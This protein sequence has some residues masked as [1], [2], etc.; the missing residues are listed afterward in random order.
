MKHLENEI[1]EIDLIQQNKVF[2]EKFYKKLDS[3]VN[4]TS[5]LMDMN[6]N[7]YKNNNNFSLSSNNKIENTLKECIKYNIIL[8]NKENKDLPSVNDE[9]LKEY[10][11]VTGISISR[12]K[13]LNLKIDF[14][15]LGVKNEYYIILSFQKNIFC[16]VDI[17]P[18][19]INYKKYIEQHNKSED[20]TTFLCKLVNYELIPYYQNNNYK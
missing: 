1:L 8:Q 6:N 13:D 2:K 9:I 16:V 12:T 20:I 3:I 15:F 4:D 14:D 11:K 7:I 19:D 17:N 5:S 10:N 18:K